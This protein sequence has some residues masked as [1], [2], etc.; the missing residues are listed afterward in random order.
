VSNF[1]GKILLCP[2]K[3]TASV[4][5]LLRKSGATLRKPFST[6]WTSTIDGGTKI[7]STGIAAFVRCEFL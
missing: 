5:L 1:G 3:Q 4:F 6:S 7:K 2:I